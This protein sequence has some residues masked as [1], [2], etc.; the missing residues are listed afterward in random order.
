LNRRIGVEISRPPKHRK[1]ALNKG[2]ES[3]P[4]NCDQGDLALVWMP[5]KARPRIA[6]R[7]GAGSDGGG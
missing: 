2:R 7:V 1:P 5:T 3:N 6:S 4:G